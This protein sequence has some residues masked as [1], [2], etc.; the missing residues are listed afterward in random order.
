MPL[1]IT[2]LLAQLPKVTKTGN[3]PYPKVRL[4]LTRLPSSYPLK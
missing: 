1:S 4:V 2:Y 3:L